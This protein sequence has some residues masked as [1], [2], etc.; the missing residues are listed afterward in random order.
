MS[1][2]FR[3]ARERLRDRRRLPARCLSI[4]RMED[5]LA[6]SAGSAAADIAAAVLGDAVVGGAVVGGAVVGGAGVD[7][8]GVKVGVIS[9]GIAHYADVAGETPNPKLPTT[10]TV[11]PTLSGHPTDDEGT[12]MLEVV[13]SVAPGAQLFFAGYPS[14]GSRITASEMRDAIQWMM[15]NDVDVIVDALDFYDQP[16]FEDGAGTV[17]QRVAEAIEEGVVYVSAAGDSAMRHYQGVYQS[18]GGDFP[19]RHDFDN[20]AST[21]SFLRFRV[22]PQ[23]EVD[24]VLQWSDPWGA[25]ANDYTLVLWNDPPTQVLASSAN[26]QNG[27]GNPLERISAIR[28]SSAQDVYLNISV[29]KSATAL[30]RELEVFVTE[31]SGTGF[32]DTVITDDDA[33][34]GDTIHGHKAVNGVITVGAIEPTLPL[35]TVWAGSSRGPSTV[36]TNFSTQAKQPRNSLDGVAI[37]AVE[38]RVGQFGYFANPFVGTAASAANVAGIVALMQ[39]AHDNLAPTEG[40]RLTPAQVATILANTAVDIGAAGYDQSTGAGRFDAIAAVAAVSTQPKVSLVT[41]R[42]TA[43]VHGGYRVKDRNGTSVNWGQIASSPV[44]GGMNQISIRFTEPVLVQQSDLVV[45]GGGG[46]GAV[47]PST[48]FSYNA[49]TNAA[50][51]TFATILRDQLLLVLDGTSANA[52]TD[53]D[54]NRLD[55]DWVNPTGYSDNDPDASIYPSGNGVAGGNFTF[56][57]TILTGDADRDGRVTLEDLAD[58]QGHLGKMTGAIWEDGDMNGDGRVTAADAALFVGSLGT[59]FREWPIA[60]ASAAADSLVVAPQRQ[61]EQLTPPRISAVARPREPRRL[62]V[63]AADRA[64]EAG[65]LPDVSPRASVASR[66]RV[67]RQFDIER[68]DSSLP[69]PT[70]RR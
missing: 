1:R 58:L 27:T 19:L 32:T 25:S 62:V 16:I 41:V 30:A 43:D 28:N 3:R 52:V 65:T 23:A 18:S 12:A 70:F 64:I 55:G 33:T 69:Q 59:N 39:H 44:G 24:V 56:A 38:T 13:H 21:D 49:A 29:V 61:T 31:S 51:W 8:S 54:G 68:P 50:T 22:P 17:A 7:G 6:L 47:R 48:A 37:H 34:G 46:L 66:L 45:R 53:M 35:E 42:N 36:V 40:D 14:S 5:R 10:I 20:G 63:E 11:H 57:V 9:T 2:F 4:E 15:D 67:T 26:T 60:A